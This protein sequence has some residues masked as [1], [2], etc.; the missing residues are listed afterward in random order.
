MREGKE[1]GKRRTR[2]VGGC[3]VGEEKN[4][5]WKNDKRDERVVREDC[6]I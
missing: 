1:R 6:G 2:S 3:V 4:H 5:E